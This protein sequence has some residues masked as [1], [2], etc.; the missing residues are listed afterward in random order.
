MPQP[1]LTSLVA[2]A[3]C[4]LSAAAPAASLR[5]QSTTGSASA[6]T[7]HQR[8]AHDIYRQLVE[9][10]T[11]DSVGSVTKA[12]EAMAA[13]FRAAGF[14]A[15]DVRVLVP[16]GKPTKGNLVVRLRGRPG[17]TRKPVLLLAHIDV[18]AANRADWPRDPF[19]LHEEG[20]YFLGRGTADDK[21]MAAVF[22]A[23]MLRYRAEGWTPDRD[24]I[25]ALTADEEGG[26]ANG[27]H[28]LATSHHDLIDAAYALNEGSDEARDAD[29]RALYMGIQ[30]AEKQSVN[31]TLA[32]ANSGGHSS[33]PRPDNA[34]YELSHALDRLEAHTFPVALNAV[35]RA[36]FA[37]T[38][39]VETPAN[40]AAIRALLADSTDAAAIATL[41][42]SVTYR[43]IMRTTCVATRLSGGHAYNALPQAATA[44]V[45]CRIVPTSTPE[46]VRAELARIVAD[47]GVR[48]DYTV[49]LDKQPAP[50]PTPVPDELLAAATSIAHSMWG[51]IPV[52]PM[53]SMWATDGAYLRPAGIPT[54]GITGMFLKPGEDNSHGRDEKMPVKSFY[55]GLEFL[56]RVVRQVGARSEK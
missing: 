44:N 15:A 17:S 52:Y 56:D 47:S 31:Y 36:F 1:R 35:S 4:A 37:Q 27:A 38:A 23:N 43:S 45:N 32:T 22:V 29:G 33:E 48:I 51:P 49:P 9:I 13:R 30:A 5:A 16:S 55:E 8:L 46:Q 39:T 50:A 6:L 26:N 7:P 25:L 10:N 54:Y 11:A 42:R 41:G 28:W 12:A 3:L 14:P 21:A 24:L 2:L 20:G 19:V 34:I 53:M 40:A 18:V